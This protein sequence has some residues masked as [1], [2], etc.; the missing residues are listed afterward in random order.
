[1][2]LQ[3]PIHEVPANHLRLLGDMTV[4]FGIIHFQLMEIAHAV[5]G[6][7]RP[8]EQAITAELSISQ[9]RSIISSVYRERYGADDDF[10]RLDRLIIRSENLEQRRNS[11]THSLWTVGKSL[12]QTSR[13]K[14]KGKQRH[15][16]KHVVEDMTEPTLMD[17]VANFHKLAAD[18][19][20]FEV[21]VC[22]N[23][24]SKPLA[25]PWA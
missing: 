22:H 10:T 23:L 18:L 5:I 9:L 13:L 17:D 15:G 20:D 16:L 12:T 25:H 4:T 14:I 19:R 11:I 8:W 2:T 24:Q 6:L 7:D 1:M 3:R 21:E